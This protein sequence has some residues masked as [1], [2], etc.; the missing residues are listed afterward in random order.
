MSTSGCSSYLME[1]TNVTNS[2]NKE[3][4]LNPS[5][6]Y[7]KA[8]ELLLKTI[9]ALRDNEEVYRANIDIIHYGMP[10]KINNDLLPLTDFQYHLE[11]GTLMSHIEEFLDFK[12]QAKPYVKDAMKFLESLN[13]FFKEAGVNSFNLEKLESIKEESLIFKYGRTDQDSYLAIKR[14]E[15]ILHFILE[16]IKYML[17][18]MYNEL[19]RILNKKIF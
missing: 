3:I 7:E 10:K 4:K 5:I 11:N 16:E 19:A 2:D 18:D 1:D 12:E 14:I 15:A 6:N 17:K 8:K 13:N 9:I